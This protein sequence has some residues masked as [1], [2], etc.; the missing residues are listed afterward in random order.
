MGLGK[1]ILGLLMVLGSW[2]LE[3]APKSVDL[4][5]ED[6]LLDTTESQSINS[7][8]TEDFNESFCL[9]AGLLK[10]YRCDSDTVEAQIEA[11]QRYSIQLLTTGDAMPQ[12]PEELPVFHRTQLSGQQAF[13]YIG[14]FIK[15]QEALDAMAALVMVGVLE[16]STWRPAVVQIDKSREVPGVRLVQ[17]YGDKSYRNPLEKSQ[18]NASE[19]VASDYMGAAGDVKLMPSYYTV[20]LAS[21]EQRTA[22]KNFVSQSNVEELLCRQRRNGRYTAYSG[23]FETE[24]A[25]QAR[26]KSLPS[27]IRGAYVLRL[28]QE[29]M[30]S[31]DGR[32]ELK[33]LSHP[34]SIAK[35]SPVQLPYQKSY[36]TAQIASFSSQEKRLQ[37]INKN[38][39][40]D[41]ICRT[42]RNGKF[43]AYSGV[44]DSRNKLKS[45]IQG[46]QGKGV[47]AYEL[48]L[49]EEDMFDCADDGKIVL[50]SKTRPARK[51]KLSSMAKPALASDQTGRPVTKALEEKS[52]SSS[53]RV[54]GLQSLAQI[55]LG[56]SS[57]SQALAQKGGG[58]PPRH[59][60]VQLNVVAPEKNP[61]RS[62]PSV[63]E[64]EA[65]Q[66]PAF[67]RRQNI[68]LVASKTQ[69]T[70]SLK[71]Q[72]DNQPGQV[73]I[74]NVTG[75]AEGREEILANGRL[76]NHWQPAAD[77]V[78]YTVQLATFRGPIN[79]GR[80]VKHNQ[81]LDPLCRV[82]RNG[83]LAVYSGKFLEFESA[84]QYL[85]GFEAK[86][87]G[88]VVRLKGELLP[89]C[90]I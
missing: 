54:S 47:S 82:R 29:D 4:A 41:F 33:L 7:A 1:G 15:Q 76:D 30:F 32:R 3:A 36:F 14:E 51:H 28:K 59:P 46:L 10:K 89:P 77:Q 45:Y 50:Y 88:Y 72:A 69:S 65:T 11:G 80:F 39:Q 37:F 17:M 25:A 74:A 35:L 19:A 85:R 78:F 55:N 49:S 61:E 44:F 43:V 40:V 68:K 34:D 2:Q 52:S 81:D 6:E 5:V 26:L 83:Q 20:Q 31:C 90:S 9:S 18:P 23:A 71:G 86:L 42:R 66:T 8:N 63:I 53:Q 67:Y 84:R 87:D 27:S 21:F 58:L 48:K 62:N 57:I 16:P 12:L 79:E 56:D 60:V 64:E 13:V 22:R 73:A 70:D 24:A 75:P 38:A